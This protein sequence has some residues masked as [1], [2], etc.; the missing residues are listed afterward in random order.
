M[1][2]QRSF[3]MEDIYAILPHRPPF[4]FVDRV[5]K[6][7]ADK[8]IVAERDIRAEEPFFAGHFPGK[9]VM[10]GVLITDALAQSSGLLWGL[11]RK[12]SGASLAKEPQLFYLASA[13]MK[14]VAPSFPGE[15]LT[16][17]STCETSFGALFK[18]SVDACV[19]RKTIASGTMTLAMMDGTL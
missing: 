5:V 16:L 14:F 7:V 3:T 2:E 8:M 9:P 6:L 1:A 4:L 17:T 11:S 10:P 19:G 12:V 15:T 13:T 18:Y